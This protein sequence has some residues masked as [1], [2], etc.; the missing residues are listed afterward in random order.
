MFLALAFGEL[1]LHGA[2]L[3]QEGLERRSQA[4]PAS[5]EDVD[6]ERAMVEHCLAFRGPLSVHRAVS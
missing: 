2:F 6:G 3:L 1:P 5:G 4:R